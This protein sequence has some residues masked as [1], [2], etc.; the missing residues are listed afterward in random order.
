MNFEHEIH[1]NSNERVTVTRNFNKQ[2]QIAL[3]LGDVI[4]DI[5]LL[6]PVILSGPNYPKKVVVVAVDEIGEKACQFLEGRCQKSKYIRSSRRNNLSLYEEQLYFKYLFPTRYIF[7]GQHKNLLK[8]F[9]IEPFV[10]WVDDQIPV[11]F[12]SS[13]S[14]EEDLI[15][16]AKTR[17][18]NM[19]VHVSYN[20][21]EERLTAPEALATGIFELCNILHPSSVWTVEQDIDEVFMCASGLGFFINQRI[22]L[23]KQVEDVIALIKANLRLCMEAGVIKDP[24]K[25]V[26]ISLGMPNKTIAD[27]AEMEKKLFDAFGSRKI[28]FHCAMPSDFVYQ[29]PFINVCMWGL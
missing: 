6:E 7:V 18:S 19:F 9:N 8:L 16:E 14:L 20:G 1:F 17:N 12:F 28:A 3:G 26:L 5:V 27:W 10:D 22:E 21:L 2:T 4:K 25:G 15:Y 11:R 13:F 23:D 24:L 29:R